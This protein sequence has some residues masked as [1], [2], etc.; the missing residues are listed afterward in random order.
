MLD[1][2]FISH[3]A[4]LRAGID[5]RRARAGPGDECAAPA[6]LKDLLAFYR[7]GRQR[8]RAGFSQEQIDRMAVEP[9]DDDEA[10]DDDKPTIAHGALLRAQ[11]SLYCIG[12][13]TPPLGYIGVAHMPLHSFGARAIFAALAPKFLI[14]SRA[15][16]SISPPY[17][18][19][20]IS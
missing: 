12:D 16:R 14:M 18:D 15:S 5:K 1:H 11:S 7:H 2:F 4:G 13:I 10:D 8:R 9:E 6:G 17:S 19:I 20:T 3:C